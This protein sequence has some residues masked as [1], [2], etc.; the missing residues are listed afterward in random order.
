MSGLLFDRV[1]TVTA[2]PPGGPGLTYEGLRISFDCN[3]TGGRHPSQ[4]R[5]RIYNIAPNQIGLFKPRKN[6]VALNVGHGGV[7]KL[8]FRGNPVRDGTRYALTGAGDRV[9]DV[10]LSDGGSGYSDSYIVQ[11][12]SGDTPAG[13]VLDAILDAT[14]WTRGDIDAALNKVTL[15]GSTTFTDKAPDILD[16][17]ASWLPG[18]GSWF[19][20]DG[21]LYVKKTGDTTS[22]R[23][24]SISQAAGNLIGSPT[25][26]RKGVKVTAI[27]D[28]AMRPGQRV[29][30][31]HDLVSGFFYVT[32]VHFYGDSGFSDEFY[33]DVTARRIGVA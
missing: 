17:M 2:G 23:G 18:G 1:V 12:F 20:R 25:P 9:L 11:T 14:G 22:E 19:V 24:L 15:A 29:A 21:A 6:V 7:A 13:L 3:H 10:E 26:T 8:L 28:A 33:M 16:R 5:V 30:V 31:Q 4:G 27:I 32:D